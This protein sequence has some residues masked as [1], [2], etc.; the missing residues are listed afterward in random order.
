[1]SDK[2]YSVNFAT[3]NENPPAWPSA[4]GPEA[5]SFTIPSSTMSA[6]P[7][8]DRAIR[9][10]RMRRRARPPRRFEDQIASRAMF[11]AIDLLRVC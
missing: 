3:A 9:A 2:K 1:M 6:H 10:A 8:F 11:V 4:A 7:C 5:V